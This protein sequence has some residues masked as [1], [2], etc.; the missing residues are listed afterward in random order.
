MAPDTTDASDIKIITMREDL[1]MKLRNDSERC[2]YNALPQRF[3]LG[4]GLK[5]AQEHGMTERAY[6][7]FVSY[8]RGLFMQPQMGVREKQ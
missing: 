3:E 2:L 4:D 5:I 1:E 8:R 7:R 6:I